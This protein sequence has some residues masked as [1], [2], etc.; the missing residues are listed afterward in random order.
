MATIRLSPDQEAK[1]RYLASRRGTTLAEV[2]REAIEEYLRREI[3]AG[4]EGAASSEWDD[5]VGMSDAASQ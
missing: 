1:L 5:V 4:E 3:P 2:Y